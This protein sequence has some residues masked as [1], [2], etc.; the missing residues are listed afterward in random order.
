MSGHEKHH[1]LCEKYGAQGFFIDDEV[2]AAGVD[3]AKAAL[4]LVTYVTLSHTTEMKAR[5]IKVKFV[6]RCSIEVK[7]E[8]SPEELL[9][10]LAAKAIQLDIQNGYIST[11]FPS[12][13]GSHR[14]TKPRAI[15]LVKDFLADPMASIPEDLRK[16]TREGLEKKAKSINKRIRNFDSEKARRDK[17][18]K[19]R[20]ITSLSKLLAELKPEFGELAAAAIR[21]NHTTHGQ[22]GDEH[23]FHAFYSAV[24][25]ICSG[26]NLTNWQDEDVIPEALRLAKVDWVM[27]Q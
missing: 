21:A 15:S 13:S 11:R 19:S 1:D 2:K 20:A 18:R 27:N 3:V 8:I 23:D 7:K 4:A 16:E 24:G 6:E 25:K 22:Y 5:T 12:S 17:G 10:A 26:N 14:I 9:T